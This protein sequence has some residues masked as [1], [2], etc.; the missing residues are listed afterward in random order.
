MLRESLADLRYR[1]RALWRREA[2]ER[3]LDLELRDHLEREAWKWSRSRVA[4]CEA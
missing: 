2:L 1:L 3:D 4:M